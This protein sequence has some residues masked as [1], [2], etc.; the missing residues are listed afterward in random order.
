MLKNM[1]RGEK[2]KTNLDMI[3]M[4][5]WIEYYKELLNED[6]TEFQEDDGWIYEETNMEIIVVEV[7]KEIK[8]SKNGK[9]PG[10]GAINSEL[11]KYGG[12]KIAI[13]ITRLINKILKEGDVQY[14][15]RIEYISSIF[16]KGKKNDCANYRGICVTNPMMKLIGR[17]IRNRLQD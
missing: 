17:I 9:A 14:E 11:L 15:M 6:R 7:L 3:T 12:R 10:T 4:D 16:K 8:H 1:R 13:L 2:H 5:R